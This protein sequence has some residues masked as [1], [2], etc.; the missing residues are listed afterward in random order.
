MGRLLLRAIEQAG[1]SE[2]AERALRG[3]GLQQQDIARLVR[4][5]VL[6]VAGLADAVRERHRGDEVRLLGTEAARREPDLVRLDL[7]AGD[8]DGPT[9][10][11]LL[12]QVAL[13]RLAT[14][15][16]QAIGL[17]WDQVGLE[18]AQTALAFGADVLWGDVAHKRLLPVLE[19]AA[20]RRE[21]ISALIERAGRRAR[22]VDTREQPMESRS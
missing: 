13:A 9:G 8:G 11:E 15:S 7:S 18:L 10:Q 6:I 1:L 22:W 5:D 16:D 2:L 20:A 3:G 14:P 19:G 17:S 21:E 12:L 4:A